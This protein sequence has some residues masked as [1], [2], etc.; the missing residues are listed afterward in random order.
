MLDLDIIDDE[1]G[2]LES[3][4]ETTYDVCERLACLYTVRDH[5]RSPSSPQPSSDFLAASVGAPVPDLMRVLN[6]HME[7]LRTVYPAEYDAVMSR[8]KSL[9][10]PHQAQDQVD[11]LD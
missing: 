11:V 5:L 7:A 3:S 9:H 10:D 8:I 6:E 1:I 2:A 4:V